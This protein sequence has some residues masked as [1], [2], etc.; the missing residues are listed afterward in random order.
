MELKNQFYQKGKERIFSP[1]RKM[2]LKQGAI[3]RHNQLEGGRPV[4]HVYTVN[5]H[6]PHTLRKVAGRIQMALILD[7]LIKQPTL[8]ES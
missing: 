8:G 2:K 7:P 1:L 5:N 6:S 4:G 3:G